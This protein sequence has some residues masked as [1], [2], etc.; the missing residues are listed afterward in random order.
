MDPRCEHD[1]CDDPS[2]CYLGVWCLPDPVPV[3]VTLF[4]DFSRRR[5]WQFFLTFDKMPSLDGKHVVFG[6]IV[7]GMEVLD[8]IEGVPVC[9]EG[10]PQV[11]VTIADC[12][13]LPD[14]VP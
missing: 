5:L 1:S 2:L 6:E 9:S 13:I 10:K 14:F 11:A 4:N 7:S 8:M 3:A 12:G